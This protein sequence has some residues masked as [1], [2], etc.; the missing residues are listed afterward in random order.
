MKKYFLTSL[1]FLF[2]TAPIL[3]PIFAQGP[4]F[5][6]AAYSYPDITNTNIQEED[7]YVIITA[8]ITDIS[9]IWAAVITIRDSEGWEEE[10]AIL[11]D[12]GLHQ[13]GA[14]NDNIYGRQISTTSYEVDTYDVEIFAVDYFGYGGDRI[15]PM[16]SFDIGS[17]AVPESCDTDAQGNEICITISGSPGLVTSIDSFDVTTLL[18]YEREKHDSVATP[19]AEYWVKVPTIS[20]TQD[21]D[22]YI[23]Y[24]INDTPDGADPENVWDSNYKMVQHLSEASGTLYDSTSENNNGINNGADLVNNG[25]INGAYNFISTNQDYVTADSVSPDVA[26]SD[27]TISAWIKTASH[28]ST[29]WGALTVFNTDTGDNRFLPGV[30]SGEFQVFDDSVWYGGGTATVNDGVWH[31]LTLILNDASTVTT[32]VDDSILSDQSFSSP[33]SISSTDRFSIGQEWDG[34]A[35]SNWFNG[36]ID[37]VRISNTVRSVAWIKASYHSG[38]DSLLT[39]G[40]EESGIWAVDGNT[41]TIRRLVT[42]DST[43]IGSDLNDFPI[44]VKLTNSNFDFSKANPD[45]HD[46]RFVAVPEAIAGSSVTLSVALVDDGG[47]PMNGETIIF[48]DTTDLINIG[49]STTNLSGVAEIS[50][51]ILLEASTGAHSLKA[52]YSGN[53]L[54]HTLPSEETVSLEIIGYGGNQRV[55]IDHTKVEATLDDFPVLLTEANFG[56]GMF[57]LARN[58]GEDIRITK[59]DGKTKIPREI[60]FFDKGNNK[61]AVWVKTDLSSTQDTVLYI[62]YGNPDATEPPANSQYGS[63][64]V[65]DSNYKMVQHLSEA[66]GTLYDSTSE[67][68]NGI[69][70]GADLVN[71]GKI[72]GAYNF[73]STNQDYV[74]ADSVSPDVASSDVTISAWIKTASHSS[75]DWGALTVFNTDTGDN[76]FLPGVRSGEFQVFDD[77]VWYGGGTATVNDGVWHYLT[78]ILN[79]ASTVTTYVDDSI[80]SDQSF[81]SPTSISSTDRFSIGQEWDGPADSDWFN[82]TIDEVRISDIV[83]SLDWIRT[84]FNNQN[85]PS[86]FYSVE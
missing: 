61:M 41:Y 10:T 4:S 31:Y 35:D 17:G 60:E 81:S 8:T 37:E 39:Y 42:I 7:Y 85:N 76:R 54:M 33:T 59:S 67:N 40:N 52:S 44:L 70:N 79:D 3:G 25:K 49:E 45:G 38:N 77:S 18:Q 68:N 48:E 86:L 75:T 13:D 73:I 58:G 24:R 9:G 43:K 16:G 71:N 56:P 14:A 26:S 27:V 50:Y 66:S 78:L 1:I 32:Y 20:S 69:N 30:R 2:I 11:Y 47:V 22:F 83:R 6:I 80:L 19:E 57:N 51:D 28:S 29:D 82:G 5:E 64:N 21:T 72:N 63:E 62:Y 36:T 15:L 23:Y 12:D 84:S 55:T 46:I 53:R 34:S 65:W 74:T